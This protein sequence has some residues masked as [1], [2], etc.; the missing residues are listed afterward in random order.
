MQFYRI[1]LKYTAEACF[2]NMY[3]TKSHF[4]EYV[5]CTNSI[6]Y[7]AQWNCNSCQE[8]FRKL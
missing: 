2:R 4:I 6:V 5:D 3:T 8:Y 1:K 7:F